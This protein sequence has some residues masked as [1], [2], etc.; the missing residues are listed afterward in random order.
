MTLAALPATADT[1]QIALTYG[2]S[3]LCSGAGSGAANCGGNYGTITMTL[4]AD[5]KSITVTETLTNSNSYLW[6]HGSNQPIFGFNY[7]GTNALS[8]SGISLSGY[9]GY[10]VKTGIA[11]SG[12]GTFEYA[13]TAN[14]SNSHTGTTLTFTV[15][16]TNGSTFSSANVLNVN[17]SSGFGFASQIYDAS[18]GKNGIAGA[19]DASPAP[20]PEPAS[21]ALI[22]SG[23]AALGG[24]VRR[25]SSKKQ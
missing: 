18:S 19:P 5:A 1:V 24:Y 15:T 3:G 23:L 22:G 2:N 8:I 10:S 25:R 14:S 21:L 20:V 16:A 17:D 4:S 11:M 12:F 9:T 7:S 6:T 13:I